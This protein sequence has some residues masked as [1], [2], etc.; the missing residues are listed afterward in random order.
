MVKIY[1]CSDDL[2][3]IE[4]SKY[5]EDEIG[6]YDSDVKIWFSDGTEIEIGYCKPGMGVWWINV[7]KQGTATQTLTI[8]E[9]EDAEIYSDIFEIDA[10]IVKHEVD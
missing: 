9:D 7:L 3:E 1:G 5:P 4:G 10:E 2:V 8:C 6:C